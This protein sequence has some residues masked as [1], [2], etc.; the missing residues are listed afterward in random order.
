MIFTPGLSRWAVLAFFIFANTLYIL[1]HK[2]FLDQPYFHHRFYHYGETSKYGPEL[3]FLK[4]SFLH[5][6]SHAGLCLILSFTPIHFTS[7]MFN[8]FKVPKTRNILFLL[9]DYHA[10]MCMHFSFT[11]FRHLKVPTTGNI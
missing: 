9:Q 10:G 4:P 8:H 3:Q 6:N 7:E 5:Q 11:P 2:W 1:I